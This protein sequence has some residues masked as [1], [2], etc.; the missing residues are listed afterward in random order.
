M[1]E[2]ERV[3]AYRQANCKHAFIKGVADKAPRCVHCGL[4]EHDYTPPTW[5]V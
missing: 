3:I 2:E 4:C 5:I 1:T